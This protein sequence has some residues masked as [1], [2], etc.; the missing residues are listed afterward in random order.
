MRF[1]L[2]LTLLKWFC[3]LKPSMMISGE[4]EYPD[5]IEE[6]K[7]RFIYTDSDEKE[8]KELTKEKIS[9]Q[10]KSEGS[11]AYLLASSGRGIKAEQIALEVNARGLHIRKGKDP[12]GVKQELLWR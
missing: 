6:A 12:A 3:R 11:I 9:E 10:I 1:W 7:F 8:L 4:E 2:K 5:D